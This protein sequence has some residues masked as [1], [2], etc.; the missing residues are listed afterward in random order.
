MFDNSHNHERA[1]PFPLA[2][3]KARSLRKGG[4]LGGERLQLECQNKLLNGVK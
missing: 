1:I 2:I 3:S 4:F